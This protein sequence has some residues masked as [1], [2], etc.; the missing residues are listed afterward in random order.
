MK[1]R[2]GIVFIVCSLLAM[3]ALAAG[4]FQVQRQVEVSKLPP[5]PTSIMS[6]RC[7]HLT[8][9]PVPMIDLEGK[10]FGE[11]QG[12]KRILMDGVPV[13]PAGITDWENG[14]ISFEPSRVPVIEWYHEYTFAI[15][16]GA[17]KILS[18]QF[19]I[20]FPIEF[21]RESPQFAASGA[22]ITLI[23]WGGDANLGR[24]VLKMGDIPMDVVS[25]TSAAPDRC[26]IKARV[27]AK[28]GSYMIYIMEGAD[29]ISK[30]HPF[31]AR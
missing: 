30:D 13:A 29:K 2:T 7:T 6:A 17:G 10:S 16:D 9:G 15:D 12:T 19:K 1:T 3:T 11:N 20:K 25:W 4:P 18:N 21:R 26:E 23:T 28:P 27:P 14:R 22:E 8:G 24:K 5:F 31:V